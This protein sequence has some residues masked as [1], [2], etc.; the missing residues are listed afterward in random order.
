MYEHYERLIDVSE[1]IDELW[2]IY[3]DVLVSFIEGELDEADL[4]ALELSLDD[5]HESM[6]YS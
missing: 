2:D 5:K 4:V 3:N 6:W 1:T